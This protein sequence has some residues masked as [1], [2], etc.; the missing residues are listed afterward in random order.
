VIFH[1][2]VSL[3]EGIRMIAMLFPIHEVNL[4]ARHTD[5]NHVQC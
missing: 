3:P 4:Q 2:Y 5:K 1:C